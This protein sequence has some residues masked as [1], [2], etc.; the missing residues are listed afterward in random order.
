L[1]SHEASMRLAL[2]QCPTKVHDESHH[3]AQWMS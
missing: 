2:E 3:A 1:R